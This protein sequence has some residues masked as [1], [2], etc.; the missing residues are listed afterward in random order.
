MLEGGGGADRINGGRGDD[1]L[2]GGAGNDRLAGGPGND[3]LAGDAGRDTLTG[4]RGGDVLVGGAGND[5]ISAA[6]PATPGRDRRGQRQRHHQCARR[7]AGP[8]LVR[9]RA[10]TP[11]APTRSDQVSRD[12]E[13]VRRG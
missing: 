10:A 12:C 8:D 11:S 4:G 13:R 3:L 7:L 2:V 1:R 9:R 6:T 5:R